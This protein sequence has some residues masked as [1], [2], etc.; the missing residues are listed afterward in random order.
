MASYSTLLK[1]ILNE[2]LVNEIGE[3]NI[4]PLK[5]T[6]VS[7]VKYKFLVYI[8]DLTEVV[9]VDFEQIT[10]K[11]DKQFY[12]PPK[13]RDLNN[14]FNIGYEISGSEIQY[15]KTDLKTLLTIIS[16]VVDII[17]HFIEKNKQLD[18]LYIKGTPKEI[19]SEDISKKSNLYQAFIKKQ[20]EQI[21]GYG[22]DTYRNGFII[23]KKK[24]K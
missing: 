24:F 17:K 16:T 20:L 8:N 3:A 13:Y 10:D 2:V 11:I 14:V 7:P 9:N 19:G 15:A 18:G 23:V 12:F 5:W 22:Y 21:P 6:Q 4:N 1:D